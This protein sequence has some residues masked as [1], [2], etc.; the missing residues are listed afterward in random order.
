MAGPSRGAFVWYRAV[1][2]QGWKRQLRRMFSAVGVGVQRLVRVRIGSL[3]L[4]DLESG[5]VRRLSAAE[6]GR[7]AGSEVRSKA[8][9]RLVQ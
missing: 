3:R 4:D 5:S 8:W 7:L 1:I 2:T 9:R 6:R